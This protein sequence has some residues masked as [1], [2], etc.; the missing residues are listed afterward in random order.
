MTTTGEFQSFPVA[1][2]FVDREGRQRKE[3]TNIEE[4]AKSIQ[5]LGLIN[6]LVIERSGNLRAGERRFTA[7]KMLGWTHVSVQFVDELDDDEMFL[8]ELDENLKR[9]NLPWAD[10]C[11]AVT[12][13]HERLMKMNAPKWNASRTAERLGVSSKYISDHMMVAD[14]LRS[15]N[16]RVTDAPKYS[17]ARGIAQRTR[18]RATTSAI[19]T[20]KAAASLPELPTPARVPPL[21]N[22]DFHDWVKTF[23]AEPFSF[24]H[25][26]FPYGI[27][28]DKHDQGQAKSHGGYADG[29]SVYTALLDTLELCMEKV[30]SDSAHMFFWFSMDHY[31]FT[32]ERL[33]AMGWEVLPHPLVWFKSDNAGILPDAQ[34]GPRR[35]YETAFFCSR[36]R[37][38]LTAKGAK[39]NV[40]AWPGRDKS[41]HMSEK[42]EGMLKHFMEMCVDKYSRVLDP[43]AGSG[44]ALK[45][46]EALG[47]WSVLGI[48]RDKEFFD[49]AVEAWYQTGDDGD[50]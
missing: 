16:T 26:D 19:A 22:L 25:C 39:S 6:P 11:L 34:R 8:L 1:S 42:P 32:L 35:N 50:E 12:E 44:N 46:A 49:R 45:V 41:I 37:R 30:V 3:L 33:R 14:E 24:L 40:V 2:I 31:Q 18:E 17:V 29:F 7:V 28:A 10:E 27:D 15:K 4:L 43:T 21:L 9:E 13:Y 23:N 38:L 47:A 20:V 48:E 36:G 5:Q